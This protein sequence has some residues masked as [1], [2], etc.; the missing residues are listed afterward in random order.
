MD[1]EKDQNIEDESEVE[2]ESNLNEPNKEE[3]PLWL[4]GLEESGEDND[5]DFAQDNEVDQDQHIEDSDQVVESSLPLDIG[6]LNVEDSDLPEWLNEFSRSDPE[7]MEIPQPHELEQPNQI[8]DEMTSSAVEEGDDEGFI[9]IH[10]PID[11]ENQPS[12]DWFREQSQDFTE[13][14]AK[15]IEDHPEQ[16]PE[17]FDIENLELD[18]NLAEIEE[19]PSWLQEI[20][21][22]SP[23]IEPEVL[24][25][26]ES[27][28]SENDL[29]V[30]DS[31]Q[32]VILTEDDL[33]PAGASFEEDRLET[34][35]SIISAHD[36]Q[37]D[38]MVDE[39]E[40]EYDT[41][42]LLAG[43]IE[44]EEQ[45]SNQVEEIMHTEFVETPDEFEIVNDLFK[46]GS[47]S[48]ALEILESL[49]ATS[50]HLDKVE[51]ILEDAIKTTSNSNSDAWEMLGDLSL[52]KGNH[53]KAL[54][55][56]AK[57][58]EFLLEG[59]DG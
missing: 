35:H 7:A 38:E 55:A 10:I 37:P 27:L 2:K 45:S 56:Y 12:D 5:L 51:S 49:S 29:L 43:A 24:S 19:L 4:Q 42:D 18:E 36:L 25:L 17:Q 26:D 40:E 59:K 58:I 50:V 11:E 52:K 23:E 20:I 30:D 6:E 44:I 54:N 48:E 9:E 13:E 39:L 57:A 22:E 31:T 16:I 3:I 46:Q 41:A 28:E 47:D 8:P 21:E 34:I 33:L 14:D 53:A 1:N 32:P 15:L